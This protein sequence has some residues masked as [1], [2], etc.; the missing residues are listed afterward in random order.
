MTYEAKQKIEVVVTYKGTPSY[1]RPAY[2]WG[3]E[4]VYINKFEDEDGTELVWKTTTGS[5]HHEY[6]VPSKRHPEKVKHEVEYPND[7]SKL[8]IKATVKQI[9]EYNGKAQVELVRVKCVEV[10]ERAKTY[11]EIQKEKEEAQ[12]ASVDKEAGDFTWVIPYRQYKEH[13]ADCET[14]AGTYD[15][16]MRNHGLHG[17]R[18]KEP[19]IE[20]IVRAGRLKNSGVRGRKFDYY[21]VFS[22]KGD[23]NI[24]RAVC[25]ENAL[26]QAQKL[27]PTA[28]WSYKPFKN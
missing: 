2:G 25:L 21:D 9:G 13:Y 7:N 14:I 16:G 27:D 23:H 6:E 12:R 5:I 3:Y 26:K 10:I 20:I 24:M 22:N 4:T 15:S 17:Y 11:E 19:T 18:E 1:E 8:K 28:E